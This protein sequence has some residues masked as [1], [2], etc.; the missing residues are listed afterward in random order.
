MMPMRSS[1][2]S[3]MNFYTTDLTTSIRFTR[4]LSIWKSRACIEPETS[5][6]STMSMP[7]AVTSVRPCMRCGRARPTM[8]KAPARIGSS[9]TNSPIRLRP[10]RATSRARLTSEYSIAATG[11][12]RPRQSS[13]SGSNA[14]SQNQSGCRKCVMRVCGCQNKRP[15]ALAQRLHVLRGQ[16]QGGE[17]YEVALMQKFSQEPL[18]LGKRGVG[19]FKEIA[20]KLL[21]GAARDRYTESLLDIE[22]NDIGCRGGELPRARG[23]HERA[24]GFQPLQRY[25]VRQQNPCGAIAPPAPQAIDT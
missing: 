10:R 3:S 19:A 20:Q 23:L 15:C 22:T 13:T 21:G 12:R 16:R 17:F 7:W 1:G 6:P 25:F 18:M 11:P 24:D 8:I 4:W 5:R 2:R 14:I 9:H